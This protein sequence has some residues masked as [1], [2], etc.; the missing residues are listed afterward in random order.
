MT[1]PIEQLYD[2]WDIWNGAMENVVLGLNVAIGN[3]TKIADDAGSAVYQVVE[4][5]EWMLISKH[6][7]WMWLAFAVVLFFGIAA[8]YMSGKTAGGA[9]RGFANFLEPLFMFIRDEIVRPNVK[10][11]HHHH[12]HD[13]D[14]GHGHDHDHDHKH[15]HDHSHEETHK[16]ADK[17]LPFFL[18]L[19][20]FLAAINLL[21]LIPGSST[22]TSSIMFTATFATVVM[23]IYVV[24]GMALQGPPVIG[25]L[26]N[27]V[28]SC[29]LA[30][31][32]LMFV[33]ELIGVL[34]KPF[35]LTV[36]LFAN[37]TAGHCLMFA[38]AGMAGMAFVGMGAVGGG[39]VG[40]VTSGALTAIYGLEVFIALLQAY[41]F[42]YLS[43]I[44][45]GSYL[46]PEH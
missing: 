44:F 8:R 5:R 37:M 18:T 27:L 17:L 28:P 2:R 30:L 20:M 4:G 40:L 21:G 24:G 19:F 42:T 3:M 32:P 39:A 35:A 33:L 11:P 29:P 15:G 38:L 34:A 9:P 12:H 23:L 6:V 46:V 7:L 36:R 22:P 25:F 14:H 43:A 31:W 26:K 16:Y 41:I 13:H 45:I 1:P 10:D